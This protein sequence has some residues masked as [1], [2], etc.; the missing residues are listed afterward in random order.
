MVI[1]TCRGNLPLDEA[2]EIDFLGPA[3]DRGLSVADSIPGV[4]V[5][6]IH[7]SL[8][9]RSTRSLYTKKITESGSKSKA[10]VNHTLEYMFLLT[11]LVRTV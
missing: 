7:N 1:F 5:S 11:L 9:P 4:S 3:R 8:I 2:A 6:I 10:T